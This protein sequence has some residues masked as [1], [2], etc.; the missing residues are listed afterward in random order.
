MQR[1]AEAGVRALPGGYVG[2]VSGGYAI[3]GKFWL[4]GWGLELPSPIRSC[5]KTTAALGTVAQRFR[6]GYS[7]MA[8]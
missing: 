8:L 1:A 6:E 5:C 4:A 3:L 7:A 2:G